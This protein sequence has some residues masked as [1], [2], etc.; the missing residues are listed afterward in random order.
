M[1]AILI[2]LALLGATERSYTVDAS[3]WDIVGELRVADA[4]PE[5]NFLGDVL[6][7]L[8]Q[9]LPVVVVRIYAVPTGP[10]RYYRIQLDLERPIKV[11]E[12][13][14]TVLLRGLRYVVLLT[15][16]GDRT[17]VTSSVDL[18]VQLPRTRCEL[19]NRMIDRVGGRLVA[20][21]EAA[22]LQRTKAKVLEL[23]ELK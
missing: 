10:K 1:Q 21:A 11:R 13:G 23:G 16:D 19:I 15:P 4:S 20:E 7:A 5:N 2:T 9:S 14:R 3:L 22:I 12:G 17:H 6:P 18:N 8:Q